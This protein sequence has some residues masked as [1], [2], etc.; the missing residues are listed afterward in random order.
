MACQ[1]STAESQLNCLC[2][3]ATIP[4]TYLQST[5]FPVR[6][7]TCHCNPCRYVASSLLPVFAWLN[8]AP[9]A[10]VLERVTA[11]HFT[12]RCTRYF[13]STCGCVCLVELPR[14]AKWACAAGIIEPPI[15][16]TDVVNISSHGYIS[17][18][19]DGGL[20]PLLLTG[21]INPVPA[22]GVGHSKDNISTESVLDLARKSLSRSLPDPDEL[23]KASCHCG[24]VSFMITRLGDEDEPSR[25]Q[26]HIATPHKYPAYF[27]ACKSCRLATGAELQGWAY[28]PL[29]NIRSASIDNGTVIGTQIGITDTEDWRWLKHFGSSETTQRSFCS[30]CGATIFLHRTELIMRST[31]AVSVGILRADSG[32]MAREWL[33]WGDGK[34]DHEEEMLDQTIFSSLTKGWGHI[35]LRQSR[36][37]IPNRTPPAVTQ[38]L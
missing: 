31:V 15:G 19:I 20:V 7:I 9:P 1:I 30:G 37:E 18:T 12:D 11:Y 13:C 23:L 10:S 26:P 17:D 36:G 14:V 16:V 6:T 5:S 33:D 34:I 29:R 32:S 38:S 3:A 8:A 2:G 28:V 24:G 27:C 25:L 21:S 35:G 4:G 22:F